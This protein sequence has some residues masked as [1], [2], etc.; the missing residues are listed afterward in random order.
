MRRGSIRVTFGRR[1]ASIV[2]GK[3]GAVDKKEIRL[4]R[5][6]LAPEWTARNY[7]APATAGAGEE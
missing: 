3:P 1:I 2:P 6:L 5:D 4:M 7:P